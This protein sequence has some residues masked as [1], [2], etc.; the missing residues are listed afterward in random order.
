MR[1]R[2]AKERAEEIVELLQGQTNEDKA[3]IIALALKNQ[4]KITRYC[5]IDDVLGIDRI[6]CDGHNST[7]ISLDQ[8]TATIMNARAV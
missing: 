3:K 6:T 5:A 4:D 8:A 2:K 1:H 7:L